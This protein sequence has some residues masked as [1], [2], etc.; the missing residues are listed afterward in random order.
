MISFIF[1][2]THRSLVFYCFSIGVFSMSFSKLVIDTIL[3]KYFISG[4]YSSFEQIYTTF[5]T[6]LADIWGMIW[7]SLKL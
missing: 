7:F 4:S 5:G 1:L 2:Y 6:I 3:F